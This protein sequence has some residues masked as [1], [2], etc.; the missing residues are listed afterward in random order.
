MESGNTTIGIAS[1]DYSS[2]N[3]TNIKFR[4]NVLD[5]AVYQ[6]KPEYGPAS[7]LINNE[8]NQNSMEK[9]LLERMSTLSINNIQYH[10]NIEDSKISDYKLR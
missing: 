8:N 4:T 3:L 9:Y 10:Y 7:I 6:K 1:K 2:A 5:V